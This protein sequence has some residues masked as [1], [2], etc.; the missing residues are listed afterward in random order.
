MKKIGLLSCLMLLNCFL[1]SCYKEIN[2]CYTLEFLNTKNF[3]LDTFI[4][5]NAEDTIPARDY[6][7]LLDATTMS[8]TCSINYSF[9]ASLLAE[10]PGYFLTDDVATISIKSNADLSLNFP[11]GSE[12]KSLFVPVTIFLD[13]LDNSNN[14]SDCVVD[15]FFNNDYNSLEEATNGPIGESFLF[16]S[17][18]EKHL[19]A[20]KTAEEI[21]RNRHEMMIRFDFES[22]VSI[23]LK[24][25]PIILE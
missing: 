8:E 7:I 1:E 24:T 9:G 6:A 4:E 11:A 16:E 2:T 10:D 5:L 21:I 14:S 25:R 22:G 12:L 15:Y 13:C 3:T 18:Q 19:F 20:L 23:E 17:E